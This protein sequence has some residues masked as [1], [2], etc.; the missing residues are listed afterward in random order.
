MDAAHRTPLPKRSTAPSTVLV[1]CAL[2]IGSWLVGHGAH[3]ER[4]PQ[5]SPAQAFPTPG[6]P[7]P[8]APTSGGTASAP[9]AGASPTAAAP[10]AASGADG[11]AASAQVHPLPPSDPAGVRIPAIGVD[12]PLAKLDL[13]AAGALQPPPPDNP[14]LAG[15]YGGGP[16]PGSTGT[17]VIT[18]HVDTRSGPAVFFLLG[19]LTKGSTIE[20]D[21]TDGRTA[22]FTVDAVESYAKKDFPDQ[23]VYGNSGLPEL[24]VITCGG[25]YTKA[26]GYENNIVVYAT[27]SAVR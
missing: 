16:T 14:R 21:R 22:V 11:S 4:P 7:A 9:P 6:L 20:V 1:V 17:A 19:A 26:G 10:G 2:A 8:A 12:A 18:G 15:W 5:P 27:L 13:D 24:R 25:L 3:A 23:K